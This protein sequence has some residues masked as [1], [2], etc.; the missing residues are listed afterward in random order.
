MKGEIMGYFYDLSLQVH[1]FVRDRDGMIVTFDAGSIMT[2][3]LPTSI[4]TKG[5]ITGSY[6]GHGF[7]RRR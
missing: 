7:L 6:L 1:G 3:T 5:E 4:N 2:G